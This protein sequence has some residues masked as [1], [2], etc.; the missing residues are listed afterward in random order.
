M[1][2]AVDK[3]VGAEHQAEDDEQPNPVPGFDVDVGEL[4]GGGAGSKYAH[5]TSPFG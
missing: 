3:E 1:I 4:P 5:G 2:A